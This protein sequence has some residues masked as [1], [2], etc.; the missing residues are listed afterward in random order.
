[1]KTAFDLNLIAERAVARGLRV[2][3][4]TDSIAL[5]ERWLRVLP[6]GLELSFFSSGNHVYASGAQHPEA[7]DVLVARAVVAAEH[8]RALLDGAEVSP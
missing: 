3:W 8:I 7:P 6:P 2:E 4:V 5:P 1:M